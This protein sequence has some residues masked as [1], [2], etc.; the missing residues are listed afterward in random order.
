MMIQIPDP[1]TLQEL[2]NAVG[3][4]PVRVVADLLE[5]GH[6]KFTADLIEFEL[7][8]KIAKKYGFETT[9]QG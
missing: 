3:Q 1:I 2:A 7:A 9:R 5:L 8:S 4:K 6:M